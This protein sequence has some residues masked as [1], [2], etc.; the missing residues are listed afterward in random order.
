LERVTDLLPP[1]W[2]PS[3]SRSVDQLYSLIV[4]D[5]RREVRVRNYSLLYAGAKRLART[6]NVEEVFDTLE[7]DLH[8]TVARNARRWLFVHAGVVGWRDRAIVIP[9]RSQSGKT[10][11]VAALVRAGATYYSDEYAVFDGRGRVHPYARPLHLREENGESRKRLQV[12][13]LG[14]YPGVS[15]LPVGRIV[16]TQYEPG[17][18]WR[19]RLITPAQAVLVLLENTVLA[20]TRSGLALDTLRLAV[21]GEGN[22]VKSKRGEAI[23]MISSLLDLHDE[24]QDRSPGGCLQK[25][26]KTYETSSSE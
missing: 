10:S 24:A 23:D 22:A 8:F 14:G 16:V 25:G 21:L 2:S 12:E 13:G 1:G 26:G 9:G 7:S 15:P 5:G 11:L 4:G 19:P 20:R 17:A 18:R 3:R 6:M